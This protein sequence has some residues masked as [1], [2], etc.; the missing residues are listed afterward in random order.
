M[1]AAIGVLAV[2]RSILINAPP[3]RVWHEFESYE[4]MK[5]WFGLGHRLVTYEPRVGGLVRMEVEHEGKLL[6]YGGPI[7]IFDPAREVT[8]DNDMHDAGWDAPTM[9]TIRLTGT[10]GGTLV[11][12]FHHAI[13]RVGANAADEHQG[14]EGGWGMNHLNALRAIVEG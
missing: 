7:T 8:W 13:E 5:A 6:Q 1:G 12:L 2:R 9:I 3:E 11:E 14:Y 4:R 10:L